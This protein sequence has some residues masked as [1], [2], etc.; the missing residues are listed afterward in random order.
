MKFFLNPALRILLF[1]NSLILLAGAML[2]PIYALF[3]EEIG[4]S[5]LD[6]GYAG[7]I[8]ALVA[9]I[10]V[11]I[12]GRFSDKVKESELIVVAGYLIMGVGFFL[13]T[14][15]SSI[16]FLLIVQAIVGF[17]QAVYSPA[18]DALYS[19]HLD[20]KKAAQEWGA[21]EAMLYFT[22]AI[23][24]L[25][26][27]FIAWRFGFDALFVIMGLLSISS[28]FIIYLLPRKLL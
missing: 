26:G 24:A 23:G 6:A 5:I 13:Y 25:I 12:I 10:T 16:L 20:R 3:V 27:G 8:F 11:L 17:G 7:A 2:G 21:W 15:V 4:G 19:K 9:G 18:F 1:T 28:A 22:S 14:C